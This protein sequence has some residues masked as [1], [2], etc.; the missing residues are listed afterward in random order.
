MDQHNAFKLLQR[1]RQK[2]E[3]LLEANGLVAK[4]CGGEMTSS[5]LTNFVGKNRNTY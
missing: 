1:S 3:Q 4:P 2:N 5:P